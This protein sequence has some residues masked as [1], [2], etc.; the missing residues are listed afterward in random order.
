MLCETLGNSICF[1]ENCLEN[2]RCL[3]KELKEKTSSIKPGTKVRIIDGG[4]GA[5]QANGY[6]GVVIERP[7]DEEYR[8]YCRGSLS[9]QLFVRTPEKI[10]WVLGPGYKISVLDIDSLTTLAKS[11]AESYLKA[12]SDYS[13]E[14]L[15]GHCLEIGNPAVTELCN[16]F[17]TLIKL[18]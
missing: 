11:E 9:E 15:L 2:K 10:I 14:A 6:R 17:L 13:D 4:A 18:Q 3:A 5:R 12:F 16:R 1:N 7:S 8:Q